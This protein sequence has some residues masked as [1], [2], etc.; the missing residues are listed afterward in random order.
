[1]KLLTPARDDDESNDDSVIFHRVVVWAGLNKD[2]TWTNLVIFTAGWRLS[3]YARVYEENLKRF[4]VS[5]ILF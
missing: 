4:G 5:L 3:T 1:M 2:V